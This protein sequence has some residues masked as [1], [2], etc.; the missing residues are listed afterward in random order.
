MGVIPMPSPNT[1]LRRHRR[2][3]G[4]TLE[5]VADRLHA[6]VER[7]DEGEL[8]V[9]SHM[10]GRWERG[11]RQPLPR[12]VRL[13]CKVFGLSADQLG[14]VE[15]MHERPAAAESREDMQR[16]Q[17]LQLL[18]ALGL[19]QVDLAAVLWPRADVALLPGLASLTHEYARLRDVTAAAVLQPA[20][21]SHL[22]RLRGH[23]SQ[24]LPDDARRQLQRIIAETA[25]LA[26]R[27]AFTMANR[28]DAGSFFLWARDAARDAGDV[29]LEAETQALRSILVRSAMLG[30][31]DEPRA[32]LALMDGAWEL[33]RRAQDP[34]L[35]AYLLAIRGEQRASVGDAEGFARDLTEAGDLIAAAGGFPDA[36]RAPRDLTDLDAIRAVGLTMLGR[37]AEALPLLDQVEAEMVRRQNTSWRGTVLADRGHALGVM[38]ELEGASAALAEAFRLGNEH[39]HR[40][41]VVRVQGVRRQLPD[42]VRLRELDELLVSAW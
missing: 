39:G 33:A 41:N 42:H 7:A 18:A 28:G 4:W 6:A 37:P 29:G 25:V 40:H 38:G 2:L 17:L 3:R 34:A 35:H 5:D 12:Y 32:A 19:G 14:L 21:V 31:S 27:N 16:R 15:E 26:G 22:M 23:A 10:V 13:L 9:D 8:G 30:G 36:F 1:A 11:V 20:V 24:S